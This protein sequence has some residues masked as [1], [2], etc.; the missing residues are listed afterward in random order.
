VYCLS[1]RGEDRAPIQV[2]SDC[3]VGGFRYAT[4]GKLVGSLLLGLYDANGLLNHVGFTSSFGEGEKAA[5]T[6]KVEALKQ[7][8]GFTGNKPGG[9]S[10]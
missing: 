8:P 7:P 2:R 10:R 3:I 9:L 6:R 1:R 4:K 5:L